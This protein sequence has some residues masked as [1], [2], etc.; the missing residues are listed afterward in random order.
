MFIFNQKRLDALDNCCVHQEDECQSYLAD[1]QRIVGVV[2]LSQEF[3]PR[4]LRARYSAN[5]FLYLQKNRL[6][7][8]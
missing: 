6:S 8:S 7:V 4:V 3:V 1:A 5:L 2:L